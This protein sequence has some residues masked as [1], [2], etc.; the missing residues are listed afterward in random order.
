[1]GAGAT[2]GLRP[3]AT[4]ANPFPQGIAQ[5]TGS[6]LGLATFLGQSFNFFNPH[7]ANPYS[8]RWTLDVQRQLSQGLVLE[9]GYTGNHSVHLPVDHQLD[10]IPRQYLSTSPVRDQATI[11]RLTANVPNPFA[12]LLP[13]TTNN[14]S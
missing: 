13:G 1:L 12:G 4:L 10:F 6:S 9:V 2:G 7:P 14:G 11:D 3:T 5:P 8:I